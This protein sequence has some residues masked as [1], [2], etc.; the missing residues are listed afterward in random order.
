M[1]RTRTHWTSVNIQ[2]FDEEPIMVENSITVGVACRLGN[3][4]LTQQLLHA[5]YGSY[6]DDRSW[7]PIHEAAYGLHLECCKLLIE[8]GRCNVN[9]QAH[10]SVTPLM[11]VCRMSYRHNEALEVA[12]YLLN[13]G[14][15]P[16]ARTLDEMTPLIQAIKS[17]NTFLALLLIDKGANPLD[18]WY[19]GWSALH[20]SANT[21]DLVMMQKLIDL[22]ADL[23][24]IDMSKHTALMV[25]V[26][27]NFYD[28]VKLLL[29][30]AGD[31]AAELANISVENG[32]TCVMAAADAGFADILLLL[33]S[34]GADCNITQHPVWGDD[35]SRIHA[36]AVAALNNHPECVKL[37]IPHVNKEILKET[38]VDPVSAA[39]Y[40]G[41]YESICLL[42]D[43]GFST[44]VPMSSCEPVCMIIPYLRPLFARRYHTPLR[45]A[46]RKGY[47]SVVE[48][49]LKAGAKMTYVKK[50]F[51][52]FLFSFRNRIDPVILYKFLENDVDINA[53]SIERTC[54]VPDALVSAL[55]T[56]NRRQLL[57][58]L[59]CGLDPSLKNWCKCKNGYSLMYDV[60]QTTYI[61]DVDRLMKLLVFFS[62]GIPNCC[63]EVKEVVGA[64]PEVPE[65]LH[66]CRLAVRKCFRTSKL[67]HGRFLDYLPIPKSMRN[68]MTFQPIPKE[69]LPT[70]AEL[71]PKGFRHFA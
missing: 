38:E 4:E 6:P 28:G 31:R 57:L 70:Y 71:D 69:L 40:N 17:K 54:D 21:R 9:A 44:E 15:D 26:Q 42:L 2:L 23:F 30:V 5:G 43:A 49:L 19:D 34:H 45:E 66:L 27:E 8:N 59:N 53:M 12:R 50:C 64:Q 25:A 10:D 56:C 22:G 3:V 51:S 52:P 63:N 48:R 39:A 11:L 24:A 20:E 33:I 7:W 62:P 61:T 41:S 67:L 68:Y 16:N 60:M 58:L 14:A 32:L 65:L 46:V 13:N 36:I 18:V 37:L 35:G 1:K 29:K 55:G 47:S